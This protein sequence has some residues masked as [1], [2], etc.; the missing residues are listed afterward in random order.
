MGDISGKAV[1]EFIHKAQ[2]AK[3][4]D[5]EYSSVKATLNKLHL[6]AGDKLT[7]A[8]GILFCDDN[9]LEIQAAIFAGNDKLTFLDIKSFKGNLFDVRHRCEVYINA[10]MRWRADLSGS[11]R[12][13]I[14]EIPIRA[15]FE[16]IGNSLCHRDY[17]V[18]KGNEVAIFKN[19]IE[20]Y[21]PGHFPE[22]IEPEDYFSGHERSV[23]RNPLIAETM[24]RSKDIERWGSGLKRIHDECSAGNIKVEFNKLKTGFVVIFYRP[25]WGLD[26]GQQDTTTQKT[27]QKTKPGTR[28]EISLKIIMLL[29]DNPMLGRKELAKLLGDITENGVKYHL[30]KLVTKGLV[31]HVGPDKGGHWETLDQK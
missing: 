10:N 8:A 4:I 11:N 14:P 1:K 5:F 26:S 23:L 29:K 30:K 18:L 31:K 27:T 7:N 15:I 25:D 9:S 20:I 3:R 13:E 24:F 28:Q 12:K 6:L 17:S 21:N 22:G 19:R 2:A 16:A